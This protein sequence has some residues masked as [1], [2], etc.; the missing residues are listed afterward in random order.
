MR[1]CGIVLRRIVYGATS[2]YRRLRT[3]L[4]ATIAGLAAWGVV[5]LI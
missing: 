2:D 5:H 1:R 3:S 4:L